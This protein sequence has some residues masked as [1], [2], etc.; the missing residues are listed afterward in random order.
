VLAAIDGGLLARVA[1][2]RF[3]ISVSHIYKALARRAAM[4][5]ERLAGW[6]LFRDHHPCLAVSFPTS[7]PVHRNSRHSDSPTT[8]SPINDRFRAT[9][10]HTMEDRANAGIL[11]SQNSIL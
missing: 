5:S 2:E 11:I 3:R 10:K 4:A 8:I 6:S 7:K 1:A 9:E